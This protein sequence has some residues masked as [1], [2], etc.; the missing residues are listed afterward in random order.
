MKP[1]KHAEIIKA[2]ADGAVIQYREHNGS[3]SDVRRN[4]P[5]WGDDDEYRIKPDKQDY[6]RTTLTSEEF[7]KITMHH[8]SGSLEACIAIANAAIAQA[9]EDGQVIPVEKN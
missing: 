2:W 5:C 4:N 3:W 9:I 8:F 7:T 6:P 1:R